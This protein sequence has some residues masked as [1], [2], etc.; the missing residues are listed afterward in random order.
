MKDEAKVYIVNAAGHNYVKAE[1]YGTLIVLTEGSLPVFAVDRIREIYIEGLK[2]YDH[3]RDFILLSGGLIPNVIAIG[4]AI[5]KGGGRVNVLIF[6]S[7]RR[8]YIE[9]ELDFS[10]IGSNKDPEQDEFKTRYL[11]KSVND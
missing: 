3:K 9:R 5:Q 6:D 2:D 8:D 11:S 10:R 4:V 1:K 7:K